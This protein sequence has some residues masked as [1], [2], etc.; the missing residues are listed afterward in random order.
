MMAAVHALIGAA[1]GKACRSPTQAFF[2]GA[3]SHLVTDGLPHR[4]LAIPQ[5]AALLAGALGLVTATRGDDSRELA[6]AIGAIAPDIENLIGRA[7][8]L[9]DER[10]LLPTHSR[11]H[12]R[13]LPT[14]RGQVPLALICIAVL[15]LSRLVR[16]VARPPAA[17]AIPVGGAD[18]GTEPA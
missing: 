10:L 1:L 8:K 3:L 16:E 7:L 4:D 17:A 15:V 2:L 9:P 6:G 5:E 18:L 14:A 12:G 11:L 13:E